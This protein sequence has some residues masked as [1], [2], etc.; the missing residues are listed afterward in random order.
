MKNIVFIPNINL[1]DG[2]ATPYHYSVKSWSKW[3]EKNNCEMVEWTEPI[4]DSKQ[5]PIILQRE[6]VFD[7][8]EHNNVN[9]DQI[10]LTFL[11]KPITNTHQLLIMVVLNG[12][13]GV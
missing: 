10:V 5:F 11:K 13:R 2:R 12:Y 7:I 4:M 1:D 3:C 6:W 9:Y 8:L